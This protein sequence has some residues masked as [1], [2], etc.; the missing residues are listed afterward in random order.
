VQPGQLGQYGQA[1]PPRIADNNYTVALRL[2]EADADL[3]AAT[4]TPN[5]ILFDLGAND[6]ISLPTEATWKANYLALIDKYR[7]KWPNSRIFISQF[8]QAKI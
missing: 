4:G 8:R 2:A 5:Y 7:A 6:V 1:S 3:A